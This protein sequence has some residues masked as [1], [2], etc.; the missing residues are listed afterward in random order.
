MTC[1]SWKKEYQ[2]RAMQDTNTSRSC[3]EGSG[4]KTV[5]RSVAARE[6]RVADMARS[7]GG[8]GVAV[9]GGQNGLEENEKHSALPFTRAAC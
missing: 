7:V 5:A 9:E 6:D 3:G 2:K 4:L 1:S 8:R